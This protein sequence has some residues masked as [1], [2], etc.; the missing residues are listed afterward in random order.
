M[1][2]WILKHKSKCKKNS[3]TC[4]KCFI[5]EETYWALTQAKEEKKKLKQQKQTKKPIYDYRLGEWR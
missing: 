4:S 1:L 2:D 3:D 5:I